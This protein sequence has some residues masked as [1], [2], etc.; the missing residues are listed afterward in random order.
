VPVECGGRGAVHLSIAAELHRCNPPQRPIPKRGSGANTVVSRSSLFTQ[1]NVLDGAPFYT[2]GEVTMKLRLDLDCFVRKIKISG[3]RLTQSMGAVADALT[4][5][6]F[7]DMTRLWLRR[8][9]W[10]PCK[11]LPTKLVLSS[12]EAVARVEL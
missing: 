6:T 9:R 8:S 7:S 11:F 5:F 12:H 4:T 10:I 2:C 3:L 1:L